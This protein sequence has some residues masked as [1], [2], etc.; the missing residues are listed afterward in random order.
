MTKNSSVSRHWIR[1]RLHSLTGSPWSG[2]PG[3]EPPQARA[4]QKLHTLSPVPWRPWLH[5]DTASEGLGQYWEEPRVAGRG[6]GQRRGWN[7]PMPNFQGRNFSSEIP[8]VFNLEEDHAIWIIKL[9]KLGASIKL[10][11]V[12]NTAQTSYLTLNNTH[13]QFLWCTKHNKPSLKWQ[14]PYMEVPVWLSFLPPSVI[15]TKKFPRYLAPKSPQLLALCPRVMLPGLLLK[16][17]T[18]LFSLSCCLSSPS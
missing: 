9:W 18:R 5:I 6:L 12:I 16:S 10:T 8:F 3:A 14:L 11:G 13:L 7:P 2:L 17:P 1:V 4:T 15:F